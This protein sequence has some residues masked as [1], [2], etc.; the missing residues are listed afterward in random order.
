[1]PQS[2]WYGK[3]LIE[4][5]ARTACV[6]GHRNIDASD[7]PSLTRRLNETIE[8][9]ILKGVVFWGCGG[10][11]GFDL[12][13]GAAILTLREK[14]PAVRLI[15]VLP[16]RGQEYRWTEQD[17]QTYREILAAANKVVYISETYYEG[18]MAKRNRWLV[19]QSSYCVAYL[20]RERT[21]TSQT[22]RF[23]MQQGLTI[24]NLAES[25]NR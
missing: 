2:K 18:V 21:G 14:Y 8:M 11:R 25:L 20:K 7:L 15:M 22:V 4:T 16:C 5:K 19:E 23:A 10:A 1:M 17:K 12:L 3:T 6:T 24:I 13:A 9:L